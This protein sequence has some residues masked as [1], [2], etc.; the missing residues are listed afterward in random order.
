MFIGN[1]AN[2]HKIFQ[3]IID[4]YQT[5]LQSFTWTSYVHFFCLI[6][7]KADTEKTGIPAENYDF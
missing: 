6:N 5:L 1:M 3:K 7:R 2:F 4:L